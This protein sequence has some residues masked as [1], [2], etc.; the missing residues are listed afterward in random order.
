MM[1]KERL[2]LLA[3][4]TM[5]IYQVEMRQLPQ[6]SELITELPVETETLNQ[7][8]TK[9]IVK[10]ENLLY[11]T[12][13]VPEDKKLGVMSFASPVSI[14][15]NFQY[16]V[17]AQEQTIC[18][19]S[20]LYPELKKYRRTYYYHNIQNP[21]DFLFSPYLIYASDIKFIRDEKEDQILKGKFADVV[22]VAAPDVTSMR[23]N[24]KVLPAEKIAEDIY[25]KVL[26]T[27]RV[28]KN[29]ETKVLILGAF[30]CG[31]FGN[32][33]QMVAKIFKQVLDRSEF[34]GV[35][36]EIYFDIMENTQ[37]LKIFENTLKD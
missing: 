36:E 20:F 30:G 32:D 24:N 21:N 26:A 4:K 16:G 14:G 34:K 15:G 11:R 31:A 22:S 2:Q 19:N 25:N 13:R 29:H 28:F 17:N 18:R 7:Y 23:E 1:N 8:E 37:V 12:F 3:H 10:D 6:S 35:F 33:P 5:N 27:L 9:I